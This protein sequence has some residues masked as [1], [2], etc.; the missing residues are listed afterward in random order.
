MPKPQ[1]LRILLEEISEHILKENYRER[2]KALEWEASLWKGNSE[3]M[4]KRL[5]A[6]EK[7]LGVS[8][9]LEAKYKK[10]K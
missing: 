10:L 3:Q 6:M 4:T 1:P 2:I 9:E 8:Y 5:K 7:Y